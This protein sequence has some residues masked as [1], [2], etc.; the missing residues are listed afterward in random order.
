M[1][2]LEPEYPP[3]HMAAE[4]DEKLTAVDEITAVDEMRFLPRDLMILVLAFGG[5]KEHR[6]LVATSNTL[7]NALGDLAA[8]ENGLV[9]KLESRNRWTK[10]VKH[11]GE[12]PSK[13]HSWKDLVRLHV[14]L[15]RRIS[16]DGDPNLNDVAQRV[17]YFN[18]IHHIPDK[19]EVFPRAG[20]A[21]S[22]V[23]ADIALWFDPDFGFSVFYS[24]ISACV[25]LG[26]VQPT[27][28][29]ELVEFQATG[30]IL[31]SEEMLR[32]FGLTATRGCHR[33][34]DPFGPP[35]VISP[36]TAGAGG[37]SIG[38]GVPATSIL[39]RLLLI[40]AL[41]GMPLAG[42]QTFHEFCTAMNDFGARD[43][44]CQLRLLSIPESSLGDVPG[45][46]CKIAGGRLVVTRTIAV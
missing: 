19:D 4:M 12:R 23:L 22:W 28:N 32:P 25:V 13:H 41:N 39:P 33:A 29:Y 6:A 30:E 44:F 26:R 5:I 7:K 16:R 36:N 17:R 11:L 9:W 10:A 40:V 24:E 1:P 45:E 15:A 35:P 18:F 43:H 20:D 21:S 27:S 8:N 42:F 2:L 38:L 34:A 31:S 37:E 46:V 3:V 14:S